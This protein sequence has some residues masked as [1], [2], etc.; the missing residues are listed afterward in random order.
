M[1]Y[2]E[3]LAAAVVNSLELYKLFAIV[4]EEEEEEVEVMLLKVDGSVKPLGEMH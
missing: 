3:V 1:G 4:I 2:A